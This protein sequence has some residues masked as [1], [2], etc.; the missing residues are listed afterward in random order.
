M[1]KA[2]K[3]PDDLL[4]T[5]D[6]GAELGI[7]ITRVQVLIREGRLPATRIGRTWV[8]RRGDL[9]LVRNRPPGRPRKEPDAKKNKPKADE[10]KKRS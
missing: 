3:S 10:K 8:V 1:A 2:N 5:P 6:A 7:G 9:D 4:S